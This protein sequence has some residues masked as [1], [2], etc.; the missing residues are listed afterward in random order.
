MR[1]VTDWIRGTFASRREAEER[2]PGSVA[3]GMISQNTLCSMCQPSRVGR[4][5][6]QS[7]LVWR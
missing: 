5:G 1:E 3:P 7:A 2:P 6:R 4:H